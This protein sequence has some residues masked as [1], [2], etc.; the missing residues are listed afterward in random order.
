MSICWSAI[1]GFYD[2]C[3]ASLQE[4]DNHPQN[5]CPNKLIFSNSK[6]T[7]GA[8]CGNTSR[9]RRSSNNIAREG[10]TTYIRL[11]YFHI[12]SFFNFIFYS[13]DTPRGNGDHENF[14]KKSNV[15]EIDGRE[16]TDCEEVAIHIRSRGGQ[17]KGHQSWWNLKEYKFFF[18][19]KS[20]YFSYGDTMFVELT[21]A[22]KPDYR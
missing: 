13:K 4:I 20:K 9:K 21:R 15:H 12:L 3:F 1:I 19:K 18:A 16:Y 8:Y 10:W 2:D 11:V 17:E 5:E 7:C 14:F 22:L 6:L